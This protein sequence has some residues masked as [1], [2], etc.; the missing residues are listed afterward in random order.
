MRR[1][2]ASKGY[3]LGERAIVVGGGVGGLSAARAVSDRFRQVV[4]LDRDEL[5]DRATARPGVPQG[6]HPNAL[7]GGGLKAL[8]QLFPG[9]G[10]ELGRAGAV[11]IDRGFDVLYAPAHERSRQSRGESKSV[12]AEQLLGHSSKSDIQGCQYQAGSLARTRISED[13]RR[14][15]GSAPVDKY[16]SLRCSA[17]LHCSRRSQSAPPD[18]GSGHD[19]E[20]VVYFCAWDSPTRLLRK[21]LERWS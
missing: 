13:T 21:R 2:T 5:P 18:N 6:K 12:Q 14:I 16:R 19:D 20:I 11:P 7:L 4:I 15:R 9:F 8:E 17:A 3:Y 10:N 1:E